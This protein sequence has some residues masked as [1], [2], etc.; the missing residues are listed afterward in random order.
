MSA[1]LRRASVADLDPIM[2]LE[3]A[4]FPTDAWNTESMRGELADPVAGYYLVAVERDGRV[5][6]DGTG[7]SDSAVGEPIDLGPRGRSVHFTQS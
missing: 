6:L 4:S 5:F 7:L 1:V 3:R 2:V